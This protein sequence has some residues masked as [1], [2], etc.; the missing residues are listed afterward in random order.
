MSTIRRQSII[1]SFVV[2]F[3]FALG[4]LN[5][6]LF[7]REGGGFTKEQ[8]GLTATFIAI[9]NIMHSVASLGMPSFISK[10]F[11]YYKARLD[12][13]NNDML[14]VALLFNCIGFLF[15]IIFG[16]AFKDI[17][18]ERF[19]NSPDVQVYYNWLFIFGFGL[20][21]YTLL[22]SYGWQIRKA[23][24]TTFLREVLFRAFTTTL[25][26]AMTFGII[27]KFDIF[28]KVYSFNYLFIAL[29]L[30]AYILFTKKGKLVFKIS[31]VTEKFF[32]KILS[33]CSLTWT[34]GL[35]SN[36]SRVFDTLIIAA[37][38]PNGLGHAAIFTLG[39][40]I[41]SLI[42]APQRG[43][44]SASIGPLSQAWREK[45]MEKI[46]QV[47]HRSSI[48]QLVFSTAMFCLIW[49]NFE[50][51][52][53]T[54]HLQPD[55]LQAKHVFLFIGLSCIIDMGTGLNSQIIGTSTYWRFEFISSLVL[56]G[57]SL[58]LNYFL[59][60]HLGIV[61]P[62]ISNLVALTAYNFIRYLFLLRRF[63]LQP[64]TAKSLYTIIL[65]AGCYIIC[66][67]LFDSYR[68]L[69]WMIVRSLLYLVLFGAGAIILKLSPDV[70]HLWDAIVNKLKGNKQQ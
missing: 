43:I 57:F 61:G 60:K 34:G 47:Y 3:G 30:F 46:D 33:I 11:P 19:N 17:V 15:V 37:I 1:S 8:Y 20:T 13:S 9:A 31:R 42:Q 41:S 68:G 65:A 38:L 58:P 32:N 7:T 63:N 18:I 36:V 48:N 64:F 23:V 24:L 49:L 26:L 56:L 14:G 28:I 67:W 44:I 66:F 5:T 22:E 16:F 10:F 25:I 52:I 27:T 51:G 29:V 50:D 70:L 39:Q 62:A 35:I 54:F 40:F 55:Y 69:E 21:I 12:R 4:F 53:T 2:Y 6:Y 59:T 45:N